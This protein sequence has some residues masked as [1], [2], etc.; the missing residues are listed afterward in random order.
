MENY[1]YSDELQHWGIKGMKWGVRRYQNKDG[2]LTAAGRKKYS[3]SDGSGGAP[4]KKVSR[5]VRKQREAALKKA[6][7]AKAAKKAEEKSIEEQRKELLNSSDAKELYRNRD[8]LTT[9][10]I[11]ERLNRIDAEQK[12]AQSIVKTGMDRVDRVLSYAK[13]ADEIYKFATG[14]KAGKDLM[15][16]LGVGEKE[17]PEFNI[18]KFYKDINKKS[19]QEIADIAKR[20]KNEKTIRDAIDNAGGKKI[21]DTKNNVNMDDIMSYI[22]DA[23]ESAMRDRNDK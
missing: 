22:D 9:A 19:N 11:N 4:K 13:K 15:K 8:K 17:T 16:A 7:E 20:V 18:K 23:V 10:E 12:L 14:S 2:S 5:K 1:T 3:E 21:N 6:R